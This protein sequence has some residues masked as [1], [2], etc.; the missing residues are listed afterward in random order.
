VLPFQHNVSEELTL[1]PLIV[2]EGSIMR[3]FCILLA[4]LTF[5]GSALAADLPVK[6]P[7]V[8]PATPAANWTGFYAGMNAGYAWQDRRS[9]ISGDTD[10]GG[11][12][13]FVDLANNN[14]FTGNNLTFPLGDRLSGPLAGLQ[15]GYN[16]QPARQWIAGIEADFDWSDLKRSA[17]VS[18][19]P[20]GVV[21][22]QN[23]N[24]QL[25]WFGTLRGRVGYLLTDRFLVFGTGGLSYG[26][27]KASAN[28]ADTSALGFAVQVN[29]AFALICPAFTN[30]LAASQS[31]VSAGWTAGG[32]AEYAISKNLTFRVEYLHIDLGTQNLTL[33]AVP[34]TTGNGF[35]SR[36]SIMPS[37][38]SVAQ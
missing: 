12:S 19:P 6:A 36:N 21:L 24:Q 14:L 18:D 23:S 13:V 8:I 33:V 17:S 38:S 29:P 28:V 5:S 27:T 9:S 2:W 11:G 31:R 26:E 4:T 16:W 7:P 32:G 10:L 15:L 1:Q 30:C 25:D 34:P 3:R 37:T 20:G 22:V 35:A